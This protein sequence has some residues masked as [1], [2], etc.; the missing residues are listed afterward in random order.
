MSTPRAQRAERR[1]AMSFQPPEDPAEIPPA[2]PQQ[3]PGDPTLEAGAQALQNLPVN[4]IVAL[5]QSMNFPSVAPAAVAPT[6]AFSGQVLPNNAIRLPT[7]KGVSSD[8]K[9]PLPEPADVI[10]F[11]KRTDAY[12]H[13][14][15]HTYTT[16]DLKLD[17]ILSC[18]P[19]GCHAAKWYDSADGRA[20]FAS[21]EDF[22]IAFWSMYGPTEADRQ[23]Y[24]D[25][26]QNFRQLESSPV[27]AYYSRFL[28]VLANMEAIGSPVQMHHACSKFVHGLRPV[29]KKEVTRQRA[30]NPKMSLEDILHEAENEERINKPTLVPK[31]ALRAMN[32]HDG[33]KKKKIWKCFFCRSDEHHHTNCKKIA[34]RKAAG[35][36]EDRPY[37]A[38]GEGQ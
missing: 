6:P 20:S 4:A 36:W 2:A 3:Q 38:G 14:Y 10:A 7:F 15:Q 29:L 34:R 25:K 17:A 32:A 21:Y 13:A 1:A 23:R 11:M 30:R 28:H 33:A 12:F 37:R 19:P 22:K 26:F 16:E 8:E 5:F 18:F 31:P 9:E 35:T 27:R 24:D